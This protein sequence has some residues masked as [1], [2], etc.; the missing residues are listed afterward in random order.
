MVKVYQAFPKPGVIPEGY[1]WECLEASNHGH[2]IPLEDMAVMESDVSNHNNKVEFQLKSDCQIFKEITAHMDGTE[3]V[4][5]MPEK[6]S[7]CEG[8][9]QAMSNR[10]CLM[11]PVNKFLPLPELLFRLAN[12]SK[13]GEMIPS[14][15][16]A[17]RGCKNTRSIFLA[18]NVNSH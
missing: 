3:A 18:G 10:S 16:L 8:V 4:F 17:E 12:S 15:G 14:A 9:L 13:E 1:K 5:C 11:M 6:M 2:K 7:Q